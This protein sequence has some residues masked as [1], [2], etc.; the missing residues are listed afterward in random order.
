MRI[1]KL[2]S[3]AMMISLNLLDSK[4]MMTSVCQQLKWD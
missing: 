2:E 4:K 1:F 3:H